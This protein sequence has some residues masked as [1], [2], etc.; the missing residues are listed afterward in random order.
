MREEE[1][2]LLGSVK[3][4]V[5]QGCR[6]AVLW[7]CLVSCVLFFIKKHGRVGSMPLG[8]FPFLRYS[9]II[10]E[11]TPAAVAYFVLI[12]FSLHLLPFLFSP[13]KT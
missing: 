11:I 9:V 12:S 1:P 4:A 3:E 10:C 13:P 8:F 5:S 6:D 2:T 7:F